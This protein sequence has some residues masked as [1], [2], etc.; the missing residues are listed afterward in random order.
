MKK[1]IVPEF[2][3]KDFEVDKI[4]KKSCQILERKNDKIKMKAG[5]SLLKKELG[6]NGVVNRAATE[7]LNSFV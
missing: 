1:P 7:I 3:Q 5:Y 2:V 4:Y 6:E